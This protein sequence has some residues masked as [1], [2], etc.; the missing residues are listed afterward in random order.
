MDTIQVADEI[1]PAALRPEQAAAYIGVSRRALDALHEKD[2]D[3]PRKILISNRCV[4][5]TRKSL[6][7][8]LLKKEKTA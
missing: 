8:W 7:E 1:Q 6:D 2:P 4:V 5:F 3:F